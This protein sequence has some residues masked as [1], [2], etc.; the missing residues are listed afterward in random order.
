M[1]L[2][3]DRLLDNTLRLQSIPAPTLHEA[4]RAAE[5]ERTLYEDF[6]A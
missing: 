6:W 3:V 4:D 5:I 1:N 2:D